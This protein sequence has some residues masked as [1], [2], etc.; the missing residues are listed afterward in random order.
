MTDQIGYDDVP[1]DHIEYDFNDDEIPS[2]YSKRERTFYNAIPNR[3]YPPYEWSVGNLP[4]NSVPISVHKPISPPATHG[5]AGILARIKNLSASD[6]ACY[7]AAEK[8][9]KAMAW[10]EDRG[11][12]VKVYSENNLHLTALFVFEDPEEATLF[13]MFFGE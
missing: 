10:L 2:R 3:L 11:S 1:D 9:K 7:E 12:E 8:V 13:K 5:V 6:A 4:P